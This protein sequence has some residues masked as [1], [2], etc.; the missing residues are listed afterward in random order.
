MQTTSFTLMKKIVS[1]YFCFSKYYVKVSLVLCENHVKRIEESSP[2]FFIMTVTMLLPSANAGVSG[3]IEAT[4]KT[5]RIY[6][7]HNTFVFYSL[8]LVVKIK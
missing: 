3:D 7:H 5:N 8:P 2:I 1:E 6:I 4:F